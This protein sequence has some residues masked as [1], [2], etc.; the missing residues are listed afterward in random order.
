M[1][2]QPRITVIGIGN[3]IMTDDAVGLAI[4]RRL[5]GGEEDELAWVPSRSFTPMLDD[6]PQENP[7]AA[8]V[9]FVDG[10]TS[11]MELLPLI[12]DA[13]NLLILDALAGPGKVG[14]VVTLVGDQIPRLLNSKLSPHQVGLLDLLSAARLLGRE[15]QRVGV[16]GIVVADTDLNVGMSP[17][18]AAAIPEAVVA[19][20]TLIEQWLG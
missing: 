2:K 13:Q 19:A 10:G 15:P 18:V 12:Q 20:E 6:A 4:L 3:P 5:Q 16:V 14:D 9:E 11:G 17:S 8:K 1:S 7:Q